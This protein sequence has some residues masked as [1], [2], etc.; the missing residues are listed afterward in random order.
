APTLPAE[1][2]GK[3]GDKYREALQRLTGNELKD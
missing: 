1:V 3:T 2:I